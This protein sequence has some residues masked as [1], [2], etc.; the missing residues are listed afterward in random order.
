MNQYLIIILFFINLI[1]M[2]LVNSKKFKFNQK[3][4][5]IF[6]II[7]FLFIFWIFYNHNEVLI[8]NV[9][10]SLIDKVKKYFLQIQTLITSKLNLR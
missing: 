8:L 2:K 1:L 9:L 3:V 6:I 4:I 10:D 5:S 7:Q